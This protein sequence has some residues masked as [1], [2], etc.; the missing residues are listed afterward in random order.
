MNDWVSHTRSKFVLSSEA[1]SSPIVLTQHVPNSRSPG[2]IFAIP[3]LN[4]YQ[5]HSHQRL[6]RMSDM[7]DS[8]MGIGLNGESVKRILFTL[9]T[10]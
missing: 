7:S 9:L 6:K 4:T 8:T 1:I 10:V 3:R 5:R 2:S